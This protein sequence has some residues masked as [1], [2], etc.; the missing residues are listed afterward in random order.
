MSSETQELL[1]TMIADDLPRA[2]QE[3]VPQAV[4]CVIQLVVAEHCRGPELGKRLS[5]LTPAND[6]VVIASHMPTM[7]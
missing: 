1:Q 4:G 3:L 2:A 5:Q 7:K 6:W